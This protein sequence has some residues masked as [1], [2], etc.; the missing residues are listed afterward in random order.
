M[1]GCDE[2]AEMKNKQ[3]EVA[4]PKRIVS[5]LFTVANISKQTKRIENLTFPLKHS[6]AFLEYHII[7]VPVF[8]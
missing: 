8:V 6:L 7:C 2:Y 5:V 3:I 4:E 1:F